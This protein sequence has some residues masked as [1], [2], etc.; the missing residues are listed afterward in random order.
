VSGRA[1]RATRL[2]PVALVVLGAVA[3]APPARA[4]LAPEIGYVFPAGGRAGESFAAVLGGYDWTTDVEILPHTP[5]VAIAL[6]GPPSAVLIPDPPHLFG[7]RARANDRPCPREFPARVSLPEGLAPGLHRWQVASANG[8]SPPGFI[9]VSRFPGVVESPERAAP[10]ALPSPPLVIDGRIA[11]HAEIDRYR[12]TPAADGPVWVEVVARRVLSP[13]QALLRVTDA[14]GAVLVDVADTAGRDLVASFPGRAG[15]TYDLAIHDIDHA[16]D[17]SS[18]YRIEIAVGP[19]VLATFPSAL[20]RGV[21]RRVTFEGIGV[22]TGA[23]LRETVSREIVAGAG[24]IHEE[25]LAT[26]AGP[27]TVAI[28]VSEGIAEAVA[29]A[30]EPAIPA[31]PVAVTGRLEP[32]TPATVVV[33]LP[34]G[35]WRASARSACA[36]R[37]LDLDLTVLAPD[38]REVATADDASGTLDPAVTLAVAAAGPHRFVVAARDLDAAPL[39]P[40]AWRLVIE[41]ERESFE[42]AP[43]LATFVALPIGGTAKVPLPILRG[44][45]FAGG[46]TAEIRVLPAGVSPAAAGGVAA[47]AAEGGLELAAA[48]DAGSGATLATLVLTAAAADGRT[49]LH[50][51]PLLVAATMKPRVKIVPDGL[52]DV[53]KVPRGSTFRG[54]LTIERLEGFAGPVRLEPTAKQQ[55]HRQGM[56]GG[57]MVV[58]AESVH[59]EYAVFLPEWMETTRTSRFIV[60]GAVEVA[61][62]RGRTRTL[63][64]R[65]EMRLG[66]LPVG[67]IMKLTAPAEVVVRPGTVAEIPLGLFRAAEFRRPG[68]AGPARVELVVGQSGSGE[69]APGRPAAAWSAEAVTLSR[70]DEEVESAT[71]RVAVPEGIAAGAWPVTFRATALEADRHPVVSEATTTLV[72]E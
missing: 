29:D 30:G 4:Q 7:F 42:P 36:T 49:I 60:N 23:A 53:R 43:T 6:A 11:R 69:P 67:A 17:R 19:R 10:Q 71:I 24:P 41:A 55:R 65:Q 45:G 21:A 58:P 14:R 62:P 15:E 1:A 34:A 13:L 28:P 39:G 3:G 9:H 18:V 12:F 56:D 70:H 32:G 20:P 66:M 64:A 72:V 63:L 5:G 37:P 47:G 38:G 61:D 27:V 25:T 2:A 68:F 31:A 46:V 51:L 44:G 33:D 59:C 50:E 54:P 16:G 35:A 48:A 22:A 40:A 52:D 26:P 57:E 8:A